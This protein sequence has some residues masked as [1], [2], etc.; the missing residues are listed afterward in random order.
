MSTVLSPLVSSFCKI[1]FYDCV[2][3]HK[4]LADIPYLTGLVTQYL[5][6]TECS[7]QM[8]N[9]TKD[10]EDKILEDFLL[11]SETNVG[12]FKD[13]SK[14]P[15]VNQDQKY[16]DLSSFLND[17]TKSAYNAYKIPFNPKVNAVGS[18]LDIRQFFNAI[19]LQIPNIYFFRDVAR[20]NFK[21]WINPH[22]LGKNR[23]LADNNYSSDMKC[24]QIDTA[25]AFY[26]PSSMTTYSTDGGVDYGYQDRESKNRYAIFDHKESHE[27]NI[28]IN[29]L[30][31]DVLG[32]DNDKLPRN[33]LYDC[34]FSKYRC[35]LLAY[36]S[37]SNADKKDLPTRDVD[38]YIK[39]CGATLLVFEGEGDG[40]S[41]Y[42]VDHKK[43]AIA[44][45][46]SYLPENEIV[47][48]SS[49]SNL[50]T[51]VSYYLTQCFRYFR[52][53]VTNLSHY[54]EVDKSGPKRV[55][56][57]KCGDHLQAL[58]AARDTVSY[59]K[60]DPQMDINYPQRN[61]VNL[62][63]EVSDGAHAFVT[64]DRIAFASAVKYRVPIIIYNDFNGF[65]VFIS[66]K[67]KTSRSSKDAIQTALEQRFDSLIQELKQT[68]ELITDAKWT[69]FE[70]YVTLLT[71]VE[72]EIHN[73]LTN[74]KDTITTFFQTDK[75]P[76]D[77]D[78][79][80]QY[81]LI[82]FYFM[83]TCIGLYKLINGSITNYKLLVRQS[84]STSE[85]LVDNLKAQ[86]TDVIYRLNREKDLLSGKDIEELKT[87]S[88]KISD[89]V[90]DVLQ[91]IKSIPKDIETL[92][93]V[94]DTLFNKFKKIDQS[95]T[96]ETLGAKLLVLHTPTYV[97]GPKIKQ[98]ITKSI[99][100]EIFRAKSFFNTTRE[101]RF[102]LFTDCVHLC[103]AVIV[104]IAS[105][106][107]DQRYQTL[108]KS[109]LETF[110]TE[111]YRR[112]NSLENKKDE[113]TKLIR[114]EILSVKTA[115]APFG[116]VLNLPASGG[117]RY[118]HDLRKTRKHDILTSSKHTRRNLQK[119]GTID[120]GYRIYK[121]AVS[122]AKL[123]LYVQSITT[124]NP[125]KM[126]EDE[127]E[128]PNIKL[129]TELNILINSILDPFDYRKKLFKEKEFHKQLSFDNLYTDIFLQEL[130]NDC[131]KK[132]ITFLYL[133]KGVDGKP[134]N[135]L[136]VTFFDELQLELL[137][138]IYP[139]YL[140]TS[141]TLDQIV[142][143]KQDKFSYLPSESAMEI[144]HSGSDTENALFTFFHNFNDSTYLQSYTASTYLQ[145]Y[146][147]EI[148]EPNE[149]DNIFDYGEKM[150]LHFANNV[151]NKP[152]RRLAP[153]V[154]V[155]AVRTTILPE[156]LPFRP[157]ASLAP[158]PVHQ[159]KKRPLDTLEETYDQI[160][161]ND[162]PIETNDLYDHQAVSDIES[163]DD[164][165]VSISS[166]ESDDYLLHKPKK[167]KYDNYSNQGKVNTEQMPRLK[168][169]PQILK[170]NIRRNPWQ[171]PTRG[172]T[173]LTKK[174]R[175]NK[176]KTNRRIKL[177]SN[178][179]R[180][181]RNAKRI[182]RKYT[183]RNR[184]R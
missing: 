137:Q 65:I 41:V 64:Y 150:F 112:A 138:L 133:I 69:E 119:G 19:P 144:E 142:S 141:K 87:V 179:T 58:F 90:A 95:I 23:D 162:Q 100:D 17:D 29:P 72:N 70:H 74:L 159:R 114:E 127:E 176:N 28:S 165:S 145:S 10:C 46:V 149:L 160:E 172:G 129:T 7:S 68:F 171:I 75:K 20:S 52:P 50:I 62:V 181:K 48:K 110:F 60:F 178:T 13:C 113:K 104:E 4:D 140:K 97:T 61:K 33:E 152:P 71:Q 9:L 131:R 109:T 44:P 167:Q 183:I 63:H 27:T 111:L 164:E 163:S 130:T 78:Q 81:C 49:M 184:H 6:F 79:R 21:K 134:A 102:L 35:N 123:L 158:K 169:L 154:S 180:R 77:I 148:Q 170:P 43:S 124:D 16:Q 24:I 37:D 73:S 80:Y 182:K 168:F 56:S 86:I 115:V 139:E 135:S 55:F 30:V 98:L 156:N 8:A 85:P 83:S 1:A 53:S 105:N 143:E 45:D 125:N 84:T 36:I 103:N 14:I 22:Y 132:L 31:N 54:I 107:T 38:S 42:I 88:A 3:D 122:L 82:F 96:H 99:G 175:R 26:D 59:I 147:A 34:I 116:I 120:A 157:P 32:Y 177:R 166:D 51:N 5:K 153:I 151:D 128:G 92:K 67:F 47:K 118:K 39:S 91:A 106:F 108:F 15:V 12:D 101:G 121:Q 2:H 89:D 76:Y 146:T 94:S 117:R 66:Q 136:Y 173:K 40:Q 57:K 93:T 174:H 155:G 161:T 126:T 18:Q 25:A 11:D